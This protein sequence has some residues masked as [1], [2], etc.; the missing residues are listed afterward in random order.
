MTLEKCESRSQFLYRRWIRLF[1][2]MLVCSAL[3]F[4]TAPLF[5]ERP[6]GTPTLRSLVPGLT[7][8]EPIWL[9]TITGTNQGVLE[10][11]FWSIY[12]EFQ[13][14]IFAALF[15]FWLGS[16]KTIAATVIAFLA[17]SSVVFA[18]KSSH[19]ATI[20]SVNYVA[21]FLD[22]KHFGWFAAGA[23]LYKY[24][25]SKAATYLIASVFISIIASA[26]AAAL[27]PEAT[28]YAIAISGFFIASSISTSIQKWVSNR[29]LLWLGFISYPLYLIHENALIASIIKLG[30]IEAIPSILLPIIPI[31][32]LMLVAFLIAKYAEPN[33]RNIIESCLIHPLKKQAQI[34]R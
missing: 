16:N 21:S 30:H 25:E 22:F 7:F 34:G 1:P 2:A 19:S 32:A 4:L 13:F 24:H 6:A 23:C 26:G 5:P 31:A 27:K 9:S 12:V 3:V 11:A 20:Q 29:M 8:I 15:Y 28:V 33:A 10:G 14:Y 17:A 18:A